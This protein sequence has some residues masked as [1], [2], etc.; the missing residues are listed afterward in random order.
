MGRLR[1]F[2]DQPGFTVQ[3]NVLVQG[4]RSSRFE[5]G[6]RRAPAAG[7]LGVKQTLGLPAASWL[8]V[9]GGSVRIRRKRAVRAF[10]RGR[11]VRTAV[12][13]NM[14]KT[15]VAAKASGV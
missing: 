6:A 9:E 10:S 3:T 15:T 12:K 7:G 8:P 2:S 14:P 1:S 5:N 13:L 4:R 11:N